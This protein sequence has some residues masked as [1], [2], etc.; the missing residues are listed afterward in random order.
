MR[1][2]QSSVEFVLTV[3]KVNRSSAFNDFRNFSPETKLEKFEVVTTQTFRSNFLERKKTR[4][5]LNWSAIETVGQLIWYVDEWNL[6][7]NVILAQT[8]LIQLV[9]PQAAQLSNF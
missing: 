2:G 7:L 1:P 3:N 6:E 8:K 4:R 9:L 5:L